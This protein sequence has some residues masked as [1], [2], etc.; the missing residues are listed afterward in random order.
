MLDARF[1]Q[2]LALGHTTHQALADA[3]G[4]AAKASPDAAYVQSCYEAMCDGCTTEGYFLT[5]AALYL[6]D[7]DV[8]RALAGLRP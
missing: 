2:I 3:L 7:A 6:A 8:D 4:D 1:R 5:V